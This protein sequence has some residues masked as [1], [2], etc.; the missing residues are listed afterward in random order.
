MRNK[1]NTASPKFA[2][3]LMIIIGFM[4]IN[5]LMNFDSCRL[6]YNPVSQD[7]LIG[8]ETQQK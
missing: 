2:D 4:I 6:K 3:A 5:A 8:T 1:M 7:T